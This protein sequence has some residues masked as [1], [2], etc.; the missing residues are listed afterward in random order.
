METET[1]PHR[2]LKGHELAE[3]LQCSSGHVENLR[4]RRLIPSIKLGRLVRFREG[5][6]LAALEKLTISAR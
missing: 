6:V 3:I 5:D 1:N 4:N 2:L